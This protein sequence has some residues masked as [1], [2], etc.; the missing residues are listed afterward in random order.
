MWLTVHNGVLLPK[1][2]ARI[3]CIR[4]YIPPPVLSGSGLW[5]LS[6]PA[7]IAIL[8]GKHPRSG[9]SEANVGILSYNPENTPEKKRKLQEKNIF[10]PTRLR[11]SFNNLIPSLPSRIDNTKNH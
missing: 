6:Q 9:L 1:L 4:F 7:R 3:V 11:Q 5:V 2:L 10:L 8:V